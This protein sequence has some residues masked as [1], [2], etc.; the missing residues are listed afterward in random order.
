MRLSFQTLYARLWAYL[1]QGWALVH[2]KA[3]PSSCALPGAFRVNLDLG[4]ELA[5]PRELHPLSDNV[6]LLRKRSGT[7]CLTDWRRFSREHDTFEMA[8]GDKT[9]FRRLYHGEEMA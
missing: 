9:Q 4:S 6:A 2:P 7:W 3:D 1:R 8:L 5:S